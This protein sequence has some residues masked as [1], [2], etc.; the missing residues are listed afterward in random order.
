LNRAQ[1]LVVP[2]N[3]F[4]SKGQGF[5]RMSYATQK[6]KIQAAFERMWEKGF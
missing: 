5:V 6:E 4:G 3:E 1:V 2:G